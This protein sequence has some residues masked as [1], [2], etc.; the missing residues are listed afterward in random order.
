MKRDESLEGQLALERA[1]TKR[2]RE[3]VA[4]LEAG[5]A[6]DPNEGGRLR[7]RIEGVE[8]DL[9]NAREALERG[10]AAWAVERSGLNA[11][12]KIGREA[13]VEYLKGV[14]L[15]ETRPERT[16]ERDAEELARYRRLIA[17]LCILAGPHD[18][19]S[20]KLFDPATAKMMSRINALFGEG[21]EKAAR[22]LEERLYRRLGRP[23]PEGA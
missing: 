15:S 21:D 22:I 6:P 12:L 2:L 23:K 14:V 5:A 7:A 18:T 13:A 19:L 17:A 16:P 9:R 8:N 10:K 11:R 1:E 4:A 3:Y 20:E